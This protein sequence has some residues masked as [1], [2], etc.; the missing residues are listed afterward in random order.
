MSARTDAAAAVNQTTDP[1]A[2]YHID[3]RGWSFFARLSGFVQRSNAGT[4]GSHVYA[5]QP[6]FTGY[7]APPQQY[8]GMAP[9]GLAA[10]VIDR[11]ATLQD[12]KESSPLN[13]TALRIFAERLARGRR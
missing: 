2:T 6:I 11:T 8:T 1:I 13:D 7:A 10:P 5:A 3:P 9:L 12:Q 4:N